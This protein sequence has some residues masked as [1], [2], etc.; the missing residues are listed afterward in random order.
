MAR[1]DV[2]KKTDAETEPVTLAEAKKHLR[3]DWDS[4]DEYISSI[5]TVA[6]QRCEGYSNRAYISQVWVLKLTGFMGV[7]S[8]PMPNLLS[9][10]SFKCR[11]TDGSIITLNEDVNF[12]VD[13][14]VQPGII[15]FPGWVAAP[16]VSLAAGYP[17]EI[18]YTC[19]YGSD[20]ASVPQHIRHAILLTVG[21]YYE[22]RENTVIGQ[23]V[24]AM[25]L[26]FGAEALLDM[27][28][29]VPV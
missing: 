12:A 29:V 3:I 23:G 4:D 14:D 20:A 10:S 21:H 9:V 11:K 18:E 13:K 19:G 2:H 7:I 1:Y 15:Y 28:R 16:S 24:S 17:V 26:P 25:P 27:D 8:V 22:N 6:R 5:I